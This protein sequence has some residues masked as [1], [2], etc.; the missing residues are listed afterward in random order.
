[1][2]KI[3]FVCHGNICRSAMAECVMTMLIRQRGL[4]G[5]LSADSAATSG[6]EIGN[7]IYPP[8]AR[9]L[10]EKGVPVLPHAARRMT[11]GDYAGYDLLIGMDDANIR[12]MN[13]IAGGDPDG[14]I[15]RLMDYTAR[16]GEVADPWYTRDFESAWR[17]VNEGCQALLDAL[18]KR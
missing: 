10:R 12:N 11:A 6:E 9:K 14:K 15:R 3:L 18:E 1:M 7:P 2:T 16:P 8:A 13:R 4:E 17:D 5:R